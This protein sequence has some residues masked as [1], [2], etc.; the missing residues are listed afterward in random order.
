MRCERCAGERF[1][2]AGRDRSQRPLCRCRE[3]GRRVTARTGSAFRG[4]RFP[5]AVIALAVRWYLRFR[6]SYAEVAEW[7]AERDVLVDP[8]TIYDWVQA[9]TPRF[10]VA[11]RQL[12]SPVGTRWWVDERLLKSGGRWRYLCRCLDERGQIVDVVSVQPRLETGACG[13]SAEAVY[14]GL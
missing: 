6:L 10:F 9:F 4:Y 1:T 2:N 7:L 14:R 12:R 5:D 11:A 8:S 13:T 3:C